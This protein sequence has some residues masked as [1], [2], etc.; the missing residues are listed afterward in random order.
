MRQFNRIRAHT[1]CQ[2]EKLNFR[3]CISFAAEWKKTNKNVIVVCE[4][5]ANKRISSSQVDGN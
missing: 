5:L 1:Q 4:K 3:S 2:A